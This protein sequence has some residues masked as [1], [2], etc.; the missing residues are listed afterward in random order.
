M[1]EWTHDPW[2]DKYFGP[3]SPEFYYEPKT[4]KEK[5][6][7]IRKWENHVPID[8]NE[9]CLKHNYENWKRKQQQ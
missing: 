5:L 9:W 2:H 7:Y 4:G 3:I 8:G 1:S 6:A